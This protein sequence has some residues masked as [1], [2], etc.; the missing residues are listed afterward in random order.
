MVPAGRISISGLLQWKSY[1]QRRYECVICVQI[2]NNLEAPIKGYDL[3]LDVFLQNA[4][5][6]SICDVDAS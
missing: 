6:E 2:G 4:K 1:L 5:E 3:S